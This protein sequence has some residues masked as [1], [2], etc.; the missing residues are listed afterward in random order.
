MDA[1]RIELTRRRRHPNIFS[2]AEAAEYLHLDSERGLQT[3]RNNFGLIGYLGVN[4][5]YV[6]WKDDLDACALKLF[7]R[8]VKT[9]GK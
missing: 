9:R 3:L 2:S 7:G 1:I 4:R 8:D 5:S 6:Y